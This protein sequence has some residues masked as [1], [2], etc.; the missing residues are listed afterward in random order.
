ME[1]E[2]NG[3][4]WEIDSSFNSIPEY[5]EPETEPENLYEWRES[6]L[7]DNRSKVVEEAEHK[8]EQLEVE[9]VQAEKEFAI[10]SEPEEIIKMRR[11]RRIEEVESYK[12]RLRRLRKLHEEGKKR[13]EFLEQEK[14]E[15]GQH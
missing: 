7:G 9:L 1:K 10:S 8:L 6:L 14:K 3:I 13:L 12:E 5:W 11:K 4:E 15:L 2:S